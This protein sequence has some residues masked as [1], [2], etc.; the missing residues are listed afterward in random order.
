MSVAPPER[1]SLVAAAAQW[2]PRSQPALSLPP[3]TP[4]ALLPVRLETRYLNRSLLIRI[5]PDIL[6]VDSHEPQ[7]TED[8][9]GHGLR[10]WAAVD[11][12]GEDAAGAWPGLVAQ[13]GAERAAWI[14]RRTPT[15]GRAGSTRRARLG[16]RPARAPAADAL[17]RRRLQRLPG[18]DV[19]HLRRRGPAD[20]GAT[21]RSGRTPARATRR[22]CPAT[23]SRQTPRRRRPSRC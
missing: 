11:A 19:P 6:H 17:A 2:P 3:D 21:R 9:I 20:H 10:Y 12:A 7:L 5:Y 8:E 16:R 13:Y 14:A 4:I 22:R 1:P 15:A 23:T 18:G